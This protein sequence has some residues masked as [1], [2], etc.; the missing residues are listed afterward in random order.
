MVLFSAIIISDWLQVPPPCWVYIVILIA[1]SYYS[2]TLYNTT[3]ERNNNFTKFIWLNNQSQCPGTQ[4]LQCIHFQFGFNIQ[5][6]DFLVFHM[7]RQINFS[8]TGYVWIGPWW[9]SYVLKKQFHENSDS[10]S[11]HTRNSIVFI[12]LEAIPPNTNIIFN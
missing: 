10:F 3:Y 7:Q 11:F 8:V 1:R 6:W 9:E 2:H 4:F 5:I 12:N